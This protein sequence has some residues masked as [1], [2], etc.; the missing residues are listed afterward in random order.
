MQKNL[1]IFTQF[2]TAAISGDFMVVRKGSPGNGLELIS[3]CGTPLAKEWIHSPPNIMTLHIIP[4][5][6]RLVAS[7]VAVVLLGQRADAQ[8]DNRDP[9][10]IMRGGAGNEMRSPFSQYPLMGENSTDWNGYSSY[11]HARYYDVV[12]GVFAPPVPPAMGEGLP[13]DVT[14]SSDLARE[15]FY[16][17]YYVASTLYKL[18]PNE[19]ERIAAYR[20]E[21]QRLVDEI[22]TRFQELAGG[23]PEVRQAGLAELAT[24]QAVRLRA[25]EDEAEALRNDLAWV[26]TVFRINISFPGEWAFFGEWALDKHGKN[27][28]FWQP[29]EPERPDM[30]RMFSGAYFYAGLSPEQ[31]YLLPE[32]A[33]E[34]AGRKKPDGAEGKMAG[35]TGFFFLP[36]SAR[37]RLPADLPPSLE[38]KIRS[39]AREKANLKDELRRAVL[40]EDFFFISTRT[41][42]LAALAELQ[43]PRFAALETQ[44][45]AIRVGLAALG[46]PDRP[47]YTGLPD[48][49]TQ[50]MGS[51]NARKVE[52]RRVLLNR[53]RELAAEHPADR[54]EIVRQGDGLAIAQTGPHPEPVDGLAE[55]NAWQA[56]QYTAFARE[57]EILRRDIQQYLEGSPQRGT[58]T[59]DQLAGDFARAYAARENRDRYRDYAH[60]VLEPGLSPA[61]RRLFFN[62]AVAEL[63]K[64]APTLQP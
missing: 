25:L 33:Y 19:T 40:R 58:R 24:R 9:F 62:S 51:F 17:G 46:S 39:F 64:I 8:S 23:T 56:R 34:L 4:T 42:R 47:G 50:R 44:A 54:F 30:S 26:K 10:V 63:E 49:L 43:A 48:D 36:A 3:V 32:I 18:S 13:K 15:T 16:G 12:Q 55:F 53:L 57:S 29:P 2:Q 60:A 45:E 37:I 21:R 35:A 22:R 31:R 1:G 27:L 59:V 28:P 38:E 7:F 52:V 61:Q 5:T 6:V 20:S 11:D 41:R 14:D